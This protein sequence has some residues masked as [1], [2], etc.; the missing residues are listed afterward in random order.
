MN[1][2][3]KILILRVKIIRN[4]I[5]AVR[6]HSIL[7]I[8]VVWLMIAS[9]LAGTYYVPYRAFLFLQSMG[10]LGTFIIDRLLYLFFMGLFIMLIFSNGI[11]SFSTAFKSRETEYLFMLPI[12]YKKIFFVNFFDTLI[13]SSWMFLCFLI[14]IL[15]AYAVTRSLSWDFY[16]AMIIFFIPFAV[17][18]AS[19][20]SIIIMLITRY[21]SARLYRFMG[22]AAI[23]AFIV[24]ATAMI[25]MGQRQPGTENEIL[26]LLT[27]FIPHFGFSQFPFSP[28][29]WICE[30]LLRLVGANYKACVFWWL[31]LVSNA[32]FFT[33]VA[34]WVAANIYY[35]GWTKASFAGASKIYRAG[36]G[37][38]DKV[39]RWAVFLKPQMRALILKDLKTF[40]RDPL[41]W[42]QFTIFFGLL[43]IYF[44]NIRT[45][46]YENIL[47][48][49]KNI[50]SFLNLASTNLTLASLSVRFVYPQFSL[51]GRR[52]WILGLAPMSRG[53]LLFEKF[54]LNGTVSLMISLSLITISNLMLKVQFQLMIISE[55]VVVLMSFSLTAICVGLGAA[56]PNFKEDN[57]AQIVSGFGGT[58]ALVLSLLYIATA[59]GAL[60]LPFHL[61][62]T[63]QIS[64]HL[65]E[66][67]LLCAG[68]FI[69][70]LSFFSIFL[71][72][73]FGWRALKTLEL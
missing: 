4:K 40:W 26:F 3:L 7:K 73:Y 9:I 48:F 18:A 45:L 38:W 54:W 71:T 59:V 41:Q 55:L 17:I 25:F 70:I 6:Q 16:F 56:L 52:F 72:M 37:F 63:E 31:V 29:Y 14:P 60:A 39:I 5:Y 58:L 27:N 2:I 65:F 19:L 11:I 43:G 20:G 67:L 46:G 12:E 50:I 13:L 44:V 1:D 66:R 49:W 57:P 64:Q 33:R 30:G 28:N 62:V 22:M 21:L 8:C 36:E 32:L 51:E 61:L 53:Q 35:E 23:G 69:G 47:P 10:H 42:S 24:L 34:V 15:S 68:A